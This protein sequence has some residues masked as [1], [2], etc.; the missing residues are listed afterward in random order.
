MA[1]GNMKDAIGS[2]VHGALN[3]IGDAANATKDKA[4]SVVNGAKDGVGAVVQGTKEYVQD[5]TDAIGRILGGSSNKDEP[6]NPETTEP[7][8]AKISEE[9][10][11]VGAVRLGDTV[12]EQ[13]KTVVEDVKSKFEDRLNENSVGEKIQRESSDS[14][15]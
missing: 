1:I 2:N 12:A 10:V 9:T 3:G 4:G 5:A 14:K 11:R 8:S 13:A 7:E 15:N 6:K